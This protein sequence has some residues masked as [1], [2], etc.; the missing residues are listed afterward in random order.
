[1]QH[2]TLLYLDKT[3]KVIKKRQISDI[4]RFGAAWLDR[5]TPIQTSH[6][7]TLLFCLMSP[8]N[9]PSLIDRC[10]TCETLPFSYPQ[11]HQRRPI[12]VSAWQTSVTAHMYVCNPPSASIEIEIAYPTH[13]ISNE[14]T[15]QSYD[16][17]PKARAPRSQAAG[18]RD[19]GRCAEGDGRGAV[20]C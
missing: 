6:L 16:W 13:L 7:N 1:M 11:L 18:R 8:E 20:L 5:Q 4:S 3:A 17:N 15:S 19:V 12:S 9:R 2:S 14:E 10:E